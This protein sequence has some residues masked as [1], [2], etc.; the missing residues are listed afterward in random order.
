VSGEDLTPKATENATASTFAL[1][2]FLADFADLCVDLY[3]ADANKAESP[4]Q[5]TDNKENE[6]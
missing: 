1:D 6:S 2:D 5:P 4:P 3:L